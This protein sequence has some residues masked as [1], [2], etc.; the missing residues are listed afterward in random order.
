MEFLVGCVLGF[1][2]V[3]FVGIMV[4]LIVKIIERQ[5]EKKKEDEKF[6]DYKDY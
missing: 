6:D 3:C 1:Y 2:T 4:L 5:K